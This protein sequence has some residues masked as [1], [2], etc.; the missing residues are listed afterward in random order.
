MN[1]SLIAYAC[2]YLLVCNLS[3]ALC[4]PS[5]EFVRHTYLLQETERDTHRVSEREWVW[6]RNRKRQ[7]GK[8]NRA[9]T[10]NLIPLTLL[11]FLVSAQEWQHQ[12]MFVISFPLC[13]NDNSKD[14]T[15]FILYF[16][17]S[18]IQFWGTRG[19]SQCQ[20]EPSQTIPKPKTVCVC[21]C[22]RCDSRIQRDNIIAVW[23][24]RCTLTFFFCLRVSRYTGKS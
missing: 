14:K 20:A 1:H 12:Q 22:V 3:F 2:T 24:M 19:S 4:Y 11:F 7:S 16:L 15:P 18:V 21:V 13:Q 17:F 23:Q 6:M 5:L 8:K 9:R 10:H